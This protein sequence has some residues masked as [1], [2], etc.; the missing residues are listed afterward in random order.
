[1]TVCLLC[2]TS[3]GGLVLLLFKQTHSSD[4]VNN[5]KYQQKLGKH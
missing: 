5:R 3:S 1:M 4:I 2:L